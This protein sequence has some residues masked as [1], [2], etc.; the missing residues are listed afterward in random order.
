MNYFVFSTRA[1]I[2]MFISI[3]YFVTCFKQGDLTYVGE[4][5]NI[6]IAYIYF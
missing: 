3:G 6:V 5:S 2:S 4:G 1:V